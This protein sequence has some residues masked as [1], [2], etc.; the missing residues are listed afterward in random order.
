[1][2]ISQDEL[3]IVKQSFDDVGYFV[4]DL[5]HASGNVLLNDQPLIQSVSLF[6]RFNA[7]KWNTNHQ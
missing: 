2:H 6:F 4:E 7:F 5:D 1:M 3:D